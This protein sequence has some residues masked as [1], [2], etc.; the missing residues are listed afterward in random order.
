MTGLQML[1][2]LA[3]TI[4]VAMFR[5]YVASTLWNWF[6]VPAFGVKPLAKITAYGICLFLAVVS[7]YESSDRKESALEGLIRRLVE[8]MVVCGFALL[9]GFLAKGFVAA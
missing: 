9:C 4:P 2:G 8:A 3:A 5:A 7:V 6:L 1:F